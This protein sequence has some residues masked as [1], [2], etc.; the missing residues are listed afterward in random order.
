MLPGIYTH[1]KIMTYLGQ[2]AKKYM[3]KEE[4]LKHTPRKPTNF[5]PLFQPGT[6]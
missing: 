1:N 2:Q 5:I 3:K 4:P 6:S